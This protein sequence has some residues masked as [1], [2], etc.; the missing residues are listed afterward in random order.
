MNLGG[1]TMIYRNTDSRCTQ[2]M[3][4]AHFGNSGINSGKDTLTVYCPI[5]GEIYID[6][7]Y[8]NMFTGEIVGCDRCIKIEDV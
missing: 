8:K 7:L 1:G 5:C 6:Y 3:E 4:D 2:I